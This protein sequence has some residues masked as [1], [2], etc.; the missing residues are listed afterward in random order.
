MRSRLLLTVYGLIL[1]GELMWAAMIPLVPAFARELQLSPFATGLL[2]SGTGAAVLVV[3]VPAGMLADRIG[4]RRVAV[5]ATFFL[6][7]GLLGHALPPTFAGL[8][9]SRVVFGIGFG[10]LWTAGV[11]LAGELAPPEHR[12]RALALPM[13]IAGGAFMLGPALAGFAAEHVG[14]RPPFAV[15]ALLA[16][17]LG[18]SLA[19]GRG[20]AP[21]A[22]PERSRVTLRRL[23]RATRIQVGLACTI[24]AGLTGSAI[25]LIV[26]LQLADEGMG[27]AGIGVVLTLS[28]VGFTLTSTFVT[29]AGA[30][31]ATA[32]VAAVATVLLAAPMLL[33]V[34]A[35]GVLPLVVVLACRGP[36]VAVLFGISYPL[37][38]EGADEAALGRG[39]VLGLLNMAWAAA[40]VIG[41]IAAGAAAQIGGNS[42]VYILLAITCFALTPWLGLRR[43]RV[44][45][46]PAPAAVR[47]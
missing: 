28:A 1:V 18:A 32:T 36:V 10:A 45:A 22:G 17:G 12:A 30:R 11:A 16:I 31:A 6:A 24:I 15:A 4:A 26:P 42:L 46:V 14:A 38:V 2:V 39:A 5:G 9:A 13:T 35:A 33:P 8:F 34:L 23:R 7:L 21:V 27:S 40:S 37:C 41:P 3:S 25:F 44:A 19:Y 47:A 29:R 20:P 43:H